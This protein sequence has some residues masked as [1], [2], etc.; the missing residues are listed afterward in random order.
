MSCRPGSAARLPRP[1]VPPWA[2]PFRRAARGLATFQRE[3]RRRAA[4][5]YSEDSAAA[6]IQPRSYS[7]A[8]DQSTAA[9]GSKPLQF[10][11]QYTEMQ[12]DRPAGK[13]ILVGAPA[14]IDSRLAP[15][16]EYTAPLK[17]SPNRN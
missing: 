4:R 8:H 13:E 1:A 10:T 5:T 16:V 6:T 11:P 12:R 17:Q 15:A 14:R 2:R 3:V 7:R 9:A